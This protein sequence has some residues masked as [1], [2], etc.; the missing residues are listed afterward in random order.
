MPRTYKPT[1]KPPGR[2]RADAPVDIVAEHNELMR[3]CTD[4]RKHLKSQFASLKASGSA[5]PKDF[6][7]S[8]S[9]FSRM[10]TELVR[11]GRQLEESRLADDLT[12]VQLTQELLAIIDQSPEI[13]R[14]MAEHGW[15]RV[16]TPKTPSKPIATPTPAPISPPDE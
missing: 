15:R 16:A 8:L 4:V 6:V 1:G 14:L 13:Q 2:P 10:V 9:S 7:S 3:L 12:D 11:E 5:L